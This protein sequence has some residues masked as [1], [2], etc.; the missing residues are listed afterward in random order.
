MGSLLV[1]IITVGALAGESVGLLS[2]RSSLT[3]AHGSR[4][5]I[6]CRIDLVRSAAWR[7]DNP[8]RNADDLEALG[9]P[10]VKMGAF[11]VFTKRPEDLDLDE[12]LGSVWVMTTVSRGPWR[13]RTLPGVMTRSWYGAAEVGR[14][15][16]AAPVASARG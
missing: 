3:G 5:E 8:R 4:E 9:V 12:T 11:L 14:H 15:G 1:R 16:L 13:S 7:G 6:R 10:A 2:D